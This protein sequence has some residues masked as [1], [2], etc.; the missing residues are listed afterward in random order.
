MT[1]NKMSKSIKTLSKFDLVVNQF[2]LALDEPLEHSPFIEF[3][4]M[5]YPGFEAHLYTIADASHWKPEINETGDVI[6]SRP[7]NE[8]DLSKSWLRLMAVTLEIMGALENY[9]NGLKQGLIPTTHWMYHEI[10]WYRRNWDESPH[11]LKPPED[12]LYSVDESI[13]SN[14]KELN[15]L[16]FSTTQSCSG[17]AKDHADRD[18]YLPYVMFDERTYPRASAHLFTLADM[19]GWIPSYGPHNFD[20]EFILYTAE[21]AEKFWDNLVISARR[22]ADLLRDYRESFK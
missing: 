17:L 8:S 10:R 4:R 22:L 21:G 9:R 1:S 16:G 3:N 20:I 18:A 13:Q 5:S 15:D 7:K 2:S 6:L 19:T 11:Q 12:F 14:I